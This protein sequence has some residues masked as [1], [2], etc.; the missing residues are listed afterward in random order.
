MNKIFLPISAVLA[1]GLFAC[2]ED[3]S[4]SSAVGT[5]DASLYNHS[6]SVDKANQILYH[7]TTQKGICLLDDYK[8]TWNSKP[9]AENTAY[10]YEIQND[11]LLLFPRSLDDNSTE[12]NGYVLTGSSKDIYGTWTLENCS[13]YR[14]GDSREIT[15]Y[16]LE[17][18][19]F[20]QTLK[21]SES[22]IIQDIIFNNDFNF[23]YSE[24]MHDIF[25]ILEGKG[26]PTTMFGSNLFQSQNE[27]VEEFKTLH[28]NNFTVL[29]N[30]KSAFDYGTNH[31]EFVVDTTYL[32]IPAKG[33]EVR[34]I[35]GADT[36]AF[37]YEEDVM[38]KKFCNGNYSQGFITTAYYDADNIEHLIAS[39]YLNDN[40]QEFTKCLQKYAPEHTPPSPPKPTAV[41]KK[42]V[43]KEATTSYH[44]QTL[45]F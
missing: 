28:N 1:F 12:S 16:D 7:F 18:Y 36:C 37:H 13:V 15:C 3:T 11:T 35:T 10:K 38:T 4:S 17:N 21:I 45:P 40:L 33:A 20:T 23:A 43:T 2:G 29:N 27:Y 9:I 14:N 34:L 41:A 44:M 26:A 25:E 39:D 42:F 24:F 31:F 32:G 8:I 5:S 6:V 22:S 19:A 30:K